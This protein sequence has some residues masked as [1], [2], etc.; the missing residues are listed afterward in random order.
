MQLHIWEWINGAWL[1]WAPAISDNC[2][3]AARLAMAIGDGY[4]RAS[5]AGGL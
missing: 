1:A 2:H 3:A 5:C 4:V